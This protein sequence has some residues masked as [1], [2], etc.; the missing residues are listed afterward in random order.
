MGL[1]KDL[2]S[3]LQRCVIASIGP[4]TSEE[5]R[6]RGLNPD[7]EATH[8]KMGVLVKEASEKCADLLAAKRGGPAV[9]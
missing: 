7:I 1:E 9:H 4:T 2:E 8:P 6:R 5:L 3:G